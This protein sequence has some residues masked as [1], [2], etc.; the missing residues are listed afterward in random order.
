M[1]AY[2]IWILF[3]FFLFPTYLFAQENNLQLKITPE[4]P[5][6]WDQ[7]QIDVSYS[8]SANISCDD[9][10]IPGIE[11]IQ[12]FSQSQG[13]SYQSINGNVQ[14]FQKCSYLGV[15]DAETA[16]PIGPATLKTASGMLNTWTQDLLETYSQTGNL[17]L[18]LS[19]QEHQANPS[20]QNLSPEN[21]SLE[22]LLWNLHPLR[23]QLP[24]F[25]IFLGIISFFLMFGAIAYMLFSTSDEKKQWRNIL[26][27]E[28]SQKKESSFLHYFQSLKK[29]AQDLSSQEFYRAALLGLRNIFSSQGIVSA[30]SASLFELQKQE[31]FQ[32]AP[33]K[34]IFEDLYEREYKSIELSQREKEHIL[35]EICNRL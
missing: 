17:N 22:E 34:S 7:V 32:N 3:W 19:W 35:D 15:F 11:Q 30:Q 14:S 5:Q 20:A 24:I 6:K 25:W 28:K 31:N 10:D 2:I 12:I 8:G 18:P 23:F 27:A 9:I 33:L 29:R 21:S 4:D 1:K 26:E 13:L 16:L